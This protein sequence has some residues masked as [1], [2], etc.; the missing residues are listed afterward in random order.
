MSLDKSSLPSVWYVY[1]TEITSCGKHD[2]LHNWAMGDITSPKQRTSGIISVVVKRATH[3][4]DLD[5]L[6]PL[7]D[8]IYADQY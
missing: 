4:L 3:K 7:W 5:V 8:D 6:D 1:I 2:N